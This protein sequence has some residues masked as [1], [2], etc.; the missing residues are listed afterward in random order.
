MSRISLVALCV[1][2]ASLQAISAA[3]P[4]VES[5]APIGSRPV[6]SARTDGTRPF[7]VYSS[8]GCS[9]TFKK[10]GDYPCIQSAS[11]AVSKLTGV[12]HIWVAT[13]NQD[14][15]YQLRS[16]APDDFVENYSLYVASSNQALRWHATVA[17]FKE[18]DAMAARLRDDSQKV[19]LVYNLK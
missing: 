17:T 5:A 14:R 6:A 19:L 13:G 7:A 16:K 15:A 11:Q 18:A 2:A 4:V 8:L 3:E 9:R 1:F 10:V 12:T